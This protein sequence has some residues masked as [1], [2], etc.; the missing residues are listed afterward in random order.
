M[1]KTYYLAGNVVNVAVRGIPYTPPTG[2]YV[3]LYTTSPTQ[4]GG[5]VEVSA[6]GY[7]RQAAIWTAPVNGQS[8]NVADIV[9]PVALALWGTVVAYGLVDAGLAG[10][11]LYYANLNAPQLVEVNDQI[12]FPAG[13]LQILES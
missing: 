10:N 5:G 6:L 4:S 8:S 11:L 2:S 7:S 1:P 13:Q 9:F 12:K 3:A